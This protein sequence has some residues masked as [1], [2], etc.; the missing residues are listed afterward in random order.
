LSLENSI[1][2][3]NFHSAGTY[4]GKDSSPVKAQLVEWIKTDFGAIGGIGGSIAGYLSTPEGQ[5]AVKKFLAS[6]QGVALLQNFAGTPEGQKT[7]FS[8]LPQVIGGLN[9]P[10][11]TA[12]IIA[13][14]IGNRQ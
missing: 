13:G 9:L 1:F 4:K 14:A 12:D 10:P 6:P 5:E 2:A 11:G 3:G 8:V 7:M